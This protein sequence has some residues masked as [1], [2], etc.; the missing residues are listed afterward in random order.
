MESTKE[1]TLNVE[2]SSFG[3]METL[4][5]R[6][7]IV[8]DAGSTLENFSISVDD[9]VDISL[10]IVDDGSVA[11]KSNCSEY[12]TEI[13]VGQAQG[14]TRPQQELLQRS[15]NAILEHRFEKGNKAI[16]EQ[17]RLGEAAKAEQD[18][19][20]LDSYKKLGSQSIILDHAAQVI[21]NNIIRS[22]DCPWV[23]TDKIK[24]KVQACIDVGEEVEGRY[25]DLI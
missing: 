16:K 21:Y 18:K 3:P 17:M 8:L 24:Q 12:L 14:G 19:K 22:P 6:K 11:A 7:S 2:E 25:F 5:S 13:L 20:V 23:H 9:E 1:L 10:T 15:S 4:N